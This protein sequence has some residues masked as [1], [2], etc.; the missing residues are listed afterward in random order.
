MHPA[1]RER[2]TLLERVTAKI[3]QN[4]A[5][6]LAKI[7]RRSVDLFVGR[8]GFKREW[9]EREIA[10]EDALSEADA[11]QTGIVHEFE[12]LTPPCDPAWPY[13]AERLAKEAR[14]VFIPGRLTSS[15]YA[16]A[17]RCAAFFRTEGKS[18][19]ATFV[20]RVVSSFIP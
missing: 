2:D 17:C 9:F 4:H 12:G 3:L 1:S 19:I 10:S 15:N 16:D 7:D 13:T 18:E 8:T 11:I 14:H 20:P 6:E 5:D